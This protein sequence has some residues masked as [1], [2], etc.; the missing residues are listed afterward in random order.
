VTAENATRLLKC[1]DTLK[2]SG[3]R[4]SSLEIIIN[5][6]D[7][8][9]KEDFDALDSNLLAEIYREK[10]EFPIHLSIEHGRD[11]VV[12]LFLLSD[13]KSSINSRDDKGQARFFLF[14]LS[15]FL[16]SSLSLSTFFFFTSG[17]TPLKVALD[18]QHFRIATTVSSCFVFSF[19][20]S[21]LLLFLG[22]RSQTFF[23][24]QI[25]AD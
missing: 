14:F 19:L 9:K 7:S 21:I 13:L 3:L 8:I 11:D 5:E 25:T 24:P 15:S 4:A 17:N 10:T 18:T 16:G 22:D 6:F 2:A 12:F 20:P 23:L 1:A